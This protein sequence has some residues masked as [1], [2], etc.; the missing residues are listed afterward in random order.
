MLRSRQ[1]K[2]IAKRYDDRKRKRAHMQ[3]HL[4]MADLQR[5]AAQQVQEQL[6]NPEIVAQLTEEQIA[7]GKQQVQDLTFAAL[8]HENCTCTD[9]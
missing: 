4:H 5:Q 2:K 7:F 6:D 9:I 1:Q 3:E 8:A